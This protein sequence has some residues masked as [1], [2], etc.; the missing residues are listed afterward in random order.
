MDVQALTQAG[1]DA[2]RRGDAATARVRFQE[3]IDAGAAPPWL[4]LARACNML[5]D[6]A[7]EEDALQRQ[8]DADGR[9]LPA[10]FAMAELKARRGDDRGAGSFFRAA[11][12]QAATIPAPPAEIR[13]LVARATAF[14]DQA[15]R[16][17]QAHLMERLAE[18]GLTRP[19]PRMR[20]ALDLLLGKVPLYQQQPSMFYYPGLP[21]RQFYEREEFDWIAGIEAMVPALQQ[22]L[23]G[24]IAGE[25][26]F[27]PYITGTP[28]RPAPNHPLLNDP[29]W[30]AYYFW[31]NGT[32]VE[33]HAR[34]CPQTM[35]AL[36]LAPIPV[37]AKRS[38]MAL[39]SLLKPGTHI[40]PHYGM[41]NTRLICHIPL[42]VPEDCALRVGSE[43]RS[44]QKGKA[45]IFDDSFEHE[46]WNRSDRTR[47]IL[48]FE[49]WRPEIGEAER[50]ELVTLFETI[51]LFPQGDGGG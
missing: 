48:L 1:Y 13:A 23:A 5:G 27:N 28:G 19:S 16:R 11:I 45:L 49:I 51:D 18:A 33:D 46:A 43:T 14:L 44:W 31:Q 32:P 6:S 20:H 8:L 37:I 29:S 22:E 26:D 17:Y 3:I 2:L 34:R 42:V 50:S 9:N 47:T 4:L 12:K 15:D 39:Y 35:A 7:A 40:Q 41:L 24:V 21:Q 10:L 36:E 30:G 25:A 38:P